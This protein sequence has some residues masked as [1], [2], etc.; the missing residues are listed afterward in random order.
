MISA[1]SASAKCI[2]LAII[3][4]LPKLMNPNSIP[5]I[6]DSFE[7]SLSTT[8]AVIYQFVTTNWYIALKIE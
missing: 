5:S 1:I 3:S 7:P 4:L 2:N 8:K 6:Y